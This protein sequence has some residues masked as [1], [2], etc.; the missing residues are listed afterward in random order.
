[1]L[2]RPAIADGCNLFP[3]PFPNPVRRADG[4]FQGQDLSG[5][6][7]PKAADWPLTA[8]VDYEMAVGSNLG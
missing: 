2:W 5:A 4:V 8:G 3:I 1:M 6:P 7:L